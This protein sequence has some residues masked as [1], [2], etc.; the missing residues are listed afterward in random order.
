MLCDTEVINSKGEERTFLEF[1]LN[2][3][4]NQKLLD[5]TVA[6]FVWYDWTVGVL[7][8]STSAMF[9]IILNFNYQQLIGKSD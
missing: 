9:N 7:R 3:E 4:S 2:N 1:G 8:D 5:M 6:M